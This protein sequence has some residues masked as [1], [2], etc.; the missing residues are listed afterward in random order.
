MKS[1]INKSILYSLVLCM[2]MMAFFTSCEENYTGKYKMTDGVPTIYFIRYQNIDQ[3]G[4]LLE[5]A[6]MGDNIL[7][8]GDNLTSIK[9]ISFNNVKAVLNINLITKNTL[10]V[11]IP[12]E[13]PSDRTDKIYFV[14]KNSET[15]T[16]DFEVKIP[17]P[18]IDRMKCEW[19]PEGGD[20]V[21]Y[22]DYFLATDPSRMK[23]FV[24]DYEIPTSDI[25]SYEKTKLVFKAPPLDIRGPLEV[26][27]LYGTSGRS[28][29]IFRDER[30]MIT[31][32]DDDYPMVAGWGR[33][34]AGTIREDPEYSLVGKYWRLATT[35][36]EGE[37]DDTWAQ[38]DAL[39]FH[40]WGEDNGKPTGNLF[41]SDPKTSTLKFEVNV[42]Q[43]WSAIGLLFFFH[44]QETTNGPMWDNGYPVGI[45]MPWFGGW[46]DKEKRDAIV[47]PYTTDGWVTVSMPLSE[48]NKDNQ[49]D[50]GGSS[51]L[52]Q[53]FPPAFGAFTIVLM[54][55][56]AKGVA[57]SPVIL[58]DNFRVVP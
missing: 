9:E 3:E 56:G 38:K 41:P 8:I 10:F 26:K 14:T 48:F 49:G 24:E 21:V 22:G 37:A 20:V 51:M 50:Q 11:T 12:R 55:G 57:C 28:K 53:D 2:G 46:E 18:I 19:V 43:D 39:A 58:F 23:V 6:Y 32:F 40:Y 1:K 27:T 44:A 5:S 33:P 47:I 36:T 13:L 31:T 16:Y 15:V 30:G 7:I 35:I 29:D 45:W 25:V 17:G 42:L 52:T 4:Q 54:R 34:D